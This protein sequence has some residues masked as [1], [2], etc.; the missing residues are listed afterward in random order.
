VLTAVPGITQPLFEVSLPANSD[1]GD[2]N[3]PRIEVLSD[4]VSL[5]P[6]SRSSSAPRQSSIPNNDAPTRPYSVDR[7]PLD[8]EM[9]KNNTGLQDDK[10]SPLTPAVAR[11]PSEPL[12]LPLTSDDERIEDVSAPPR[13]MRDIMR[14]PR[15]RFLYVQVPIP[16][17]HPNPIRNGPRMERV[18]KSKRT[19]ST[20]LELLCVDRSSSSS[21]Y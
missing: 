7:I 19:S 9:D 3:L 13:R 16:K 10:Y 14:R 6:L 20:L 4:D 15:Q 1:G 2:P 17:G 21:Q 12:F 18:K 8:V 11:S 5:P